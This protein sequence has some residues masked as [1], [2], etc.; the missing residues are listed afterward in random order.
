MKDLD[1]ESIELSR[2][3]KTSESTYLTK[4]KNGSNDKKLMEEIVKLRERVKSRMEAKKAIA[5]SMLEELSRI[6]LKLDKDIN[7]FEHELKTNG[8]FEQQAKK[9]V[10]PGLEVAIRPSLAS[11]E[12]ILGRVITYHPDSGIYDITDVDDTSKQYQL[13]ETQVLN[14][15]QLAL[16]C[17]ALHHMGTNQLHLLYKMHFIE[18]YFTLLYYIVLYCITYCSESHCITS[19]PTR[20][21]F[22]N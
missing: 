15:I 11:D 8:E 2:E 6:T 1:R 9:G 4:F 16:F 21:K 3:L 14:E 10:E 19:E 12:I 7:T 22:R 20:C 13:P 5:S 17:A 18:F